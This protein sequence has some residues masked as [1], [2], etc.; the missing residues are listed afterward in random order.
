MNCENKF[1]IISSMVLV[2]VM[3]IIIWLLCVGEYL[4]VSGMTFSVIFLLVSYIQLLNS[5]I[6]YDSFIQAKTY[7]ERL[8]TA[9][10]LLE[11]KLIEE[12]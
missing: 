6:V 9:V 12:A 10:Q 11:V 7:Y 5:R 3:G 8:R 4:I 1:L 2:K